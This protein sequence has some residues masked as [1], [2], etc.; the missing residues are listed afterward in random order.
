MFGKY[1]KLS[2]VILICFLFFSLL[3][4]IGGMNISIGE[5]DFRISRLEA[6]NA[7]LEKKLSD[8]SEQLDRQL[9]DLQKC[10]MGY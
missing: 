2:I 9:K 10:G 6:D 5:R 1:L 4:A 7:V 8:Y 3:N